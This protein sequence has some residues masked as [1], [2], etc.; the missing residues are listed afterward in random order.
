M[1]CKSQTC[2][3]LD[4]ALW[5]F[6]AENAKHAVYACTSNWTVCLVGEYAGVVS[7]ARNSPELLARETNRVRARVTWRHGW[8]D[9][10]ERSSIIVIYLKL[11]GL[12]DWI[13]WT[14]LCDTRT[15]SI[16]ILLLQLTH[17]T[18]IMAH[19]S[20]TGFTMLTVTQSLL[21]NPLKLYPTFEFYTSNGFTSSFLLASAIMVGVRLAFI[22]QLLSKYRSIFRPFR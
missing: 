9:L 8:F 12:L 20:Y 21:G 18:T 11:Q 3:D 7:R 15:P 16:Y 13:C 14:V 4:S 6:H 17:S 1:V 5:H 19:V 10:C 2:I 22:Y